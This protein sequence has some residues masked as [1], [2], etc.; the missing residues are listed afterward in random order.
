M[1]EVL[2]SA[3]G[4]AFVDKTVES[5]LPVKDSKKKTSDVEEESLVK[6]VRANESEA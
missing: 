6:I 5:E 4:E 3:V 1:M 2:T